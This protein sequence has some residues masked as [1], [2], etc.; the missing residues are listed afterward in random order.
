MDVWQ[1]G[2][3]HGESKRARNGRR[4][5]LGHNQRY[6]RGRAR[7]GDG[8]GDDAHGDEAWYGNGRRGERGERYVRHSGVYGRDGRHGP[9]GELSRAVRGSAAR[10]GYGERCSDGYVPGPDGRCGDRC[11]A[12][13]HRA[14]PPARYG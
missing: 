3:G 14:G 13:L 11:E 10:L 7:D 8:D 9:P 5:R 6:E 4:G 2:R 12:E 1:P